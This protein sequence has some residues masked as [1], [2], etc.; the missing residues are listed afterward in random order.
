MSIHVETD[1]MK[2]GNQASPPQRQFY[3]DFNEI[4]SRRAEALGEPGNDILRIAHERKVLFLTDQVAQIRRRPDFAEYQ[5]E[6]QAAEL[7]LHQAILRRAWENAAR[8]SMRLAA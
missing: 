5:V 8:V 4:V 6:A 1:Q 7:A 2:S 3:E